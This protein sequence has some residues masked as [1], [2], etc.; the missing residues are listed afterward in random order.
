MPKVNLMSELDEFTFGSFRQMVGLSGDV[1]N[2]QILEN[3]QLFTDD[4]FV[5]GIVISGISDKKLDFNNSTYEFHKAGY[6]K[7]K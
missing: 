4:G 7:Q 1:D 6:V 2:K 5:K 3:L